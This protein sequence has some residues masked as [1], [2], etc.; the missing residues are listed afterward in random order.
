VLSRSTS[1]E[2]DQRLHHLVRCPEPNSKPNNKIVKLNAI[3][4]GTIIAPPSYSCVN[5]TA[6]ARGWDFIIPPLRQK[7]KSLQLSSLRSSAGIAQ[8]IMRSPRYSG[9][10]KGIAVCLRTFGYAE[11][12]SSGNVAARPRSRG[13]CKPVSLRAAVCYLAGRLSK[14][15]RSSRQ[16][17]TTA[18]ATRIPSDTSAKRC[19]AAIHGVS[20]RGISTMIASV[21]QA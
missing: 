2:A 3:T 12:A 17:P 9:I 15:R 5:C 21:M 18:S 10:N 16:T 20:A 8:T 19:A 11:P 1:V 13:S 6:M 7:V 14:S 4:I